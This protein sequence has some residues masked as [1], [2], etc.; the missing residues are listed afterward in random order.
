MS[1]IKPSIY[2][3][4]ARFIM[5]L[6]SFILMA[7]ISYILMYNSLV[8]ARYQVTNLKSQITEA[9]NVNNNLK[10]EVFNITSPQSLNSLAVK[11]N[12]VLDTKPEYLSEKQWVSDSSF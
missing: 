2:A 7:G 12:L 11:Y 8:N 5:F 3:Q 9:V 6:L 1:I 4:N 10:S